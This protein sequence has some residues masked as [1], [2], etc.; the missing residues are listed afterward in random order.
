VVFVALAT[1]SLA[2]RLWVRLRLLRR[3]LDWDDWIIIV[4]YVSPT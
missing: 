2:A 3:S 4:A 1:L